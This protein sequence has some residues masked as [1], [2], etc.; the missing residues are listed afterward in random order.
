MAKSRVAP[1][2]RGRTTVAIALIGFL[3][4]T[5]SVIARRSWG[6][7]LQRDLTTIERTRTQLSGEVIKLESEIRSASSRNKLAPLVESTLGMRVPSDTQVID[8]QVMEGARVAP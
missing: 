1:R 3:I 2:R 4:V 6:R 7:A 8:L 5:V